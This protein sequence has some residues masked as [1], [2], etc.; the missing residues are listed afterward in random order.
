LVQAGIAMMAQTNNF[1]QQVLNIL[2]K[3]KWV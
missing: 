1:P 2:S 3:V